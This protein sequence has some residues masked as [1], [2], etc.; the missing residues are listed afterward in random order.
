MKG[1]AI[2]FGAALSAIMWLSFVTPTIVRAF[3]VPMEFRFWKAAKRNRLLSRSQYIWSFGVMGFG[4][5]MFVFN[6]LFGYLSWKLLS[7]EY[8]RP[9]PIFSLILLA[10]CFGMGLLFGFMS[11]RH[12]DISTTSGTE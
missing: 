8:A 3:G 7:D 4:G 2:L 9:K 11:E 5:A 12:R 10:G 6:W 1:L